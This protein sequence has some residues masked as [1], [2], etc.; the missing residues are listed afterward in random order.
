M[1]LLAQQG[2]GRSDKIERGIRDG[3][4][5]GV[6]LSP[7]DTSADALPTFV[8]SLRQEFGDELEILFD[9]QF[10]ASVIP[11]ATDRHLPEYP[12]Y[13]PGL[14]RSNFLSA[15]DVS[16]F[17][18]SSISYQASLDLTSIVSPTVMFDSFSESS[19]QTALQLAAESTSMYDEIGSDRQLLLSFFMGEAALADTDSVYEFLDIA[20]GWQADGFYLVVEPTNTGYPNTIDSERLANLMY[21]VYSLGEI[22]EKEVVVGYADFEGLLVGAAGA[23]SMATGWYSG[24]RQFSR[25]RWL[26]STGGRAPNA[27]YS[28]S[29]LLNSITVVPELL[30][31]HRV[32]L[33]DA[34]LSDT[35]YD[36]SFQ[37]ANPADV[38]WPRPEQCLQHWAVLSALIDQTESSST[39]SRL[40]SIRE[41][42]EQAGE[43]Y[44]DL[45]ESGVVFDG[46]TGAGRLA[47]WSLAIERFTQL[48]GL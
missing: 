10:F 5:S 19:C 30:A 26:P 13:R 1:L 7:R 39:P 46:P 41:L 15:T 14:S 25:S 28:S 17:V 44:S 48:A 8:T 23:T 9:P 12:Y 32:G 29:P 20:T 6:I 2:Y 31:A 40:A 3:S 43:T 11:D 33:L 37:G 42:I 34:C 27:R 45:G 38:A 16:R 18:R 21:V 24:L 35:E 36:I 22:N 4:L 47:Q